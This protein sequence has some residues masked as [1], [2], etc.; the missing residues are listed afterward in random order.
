MWQQE[1]LPSDSFP[2]APEAILTT[3]HCIKGK[4]HENRPSQLPSFALPSLPRDLDIISP[5]S[6]VAFEGQISRAWE[7]VWLPLQITFVVDENTLYFY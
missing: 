6:F 5:Q 4:P 2:V 7:R 3:T 1:G